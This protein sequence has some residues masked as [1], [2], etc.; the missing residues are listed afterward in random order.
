MVCAWGESE[1]R[2]FESRMR[3][4]ALKL[5]F[6]WP[7]LTDAN[8]FQEIHRALNPP[9][10]SLSPVGIPQDV[11]K[12]LCAKLGLFTPRGNQRKKRWAGPRS[13]SRS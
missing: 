5:W 4:L 9:A 11:T 12:T 7:K 8:D 13:I 1:K 10:L 6:Y 3:A 2:I